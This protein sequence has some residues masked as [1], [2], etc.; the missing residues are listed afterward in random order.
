MAKLILH[1]LTTLTPSHTLRLMQVALLSG[2]AYAA[3]WMTGKATT[4][5]PRKSLR[6]MQHWTRRAK[7]GD[8]RVYED[9]AATPSTSD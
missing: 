2:Y 7:S 1:G 3:R 4:R 9:M 6:K 8:R 5:Q